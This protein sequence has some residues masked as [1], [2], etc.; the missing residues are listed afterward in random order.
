MNHSVYVISGSYSRNGSYHQ[1]DIDREEFQ[2]LS[3]ILHDA[4]VQKNTIRIKIGEG[5]L[6]VKNGNDIGFATFWHGA[7]EWISNDA[8]MTQLSIVFA[9]IATA[10][11]IESEL[12][13][14]VHLEP[15]Y[16]VSSD[17]VSDIVF[18]KMGSH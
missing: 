4:V 2:I 13:E 9:S 11:E 17:T 10:D 7:I 14:H 18:Q 1:F 3:K 16:L 12:I 15:V 8:D 6:T 5:R